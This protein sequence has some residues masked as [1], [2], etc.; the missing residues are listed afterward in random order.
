MSRQE[1]VFALLDSLH[2]DYSV[3]NHPAVF[4]IAEIDKLN[5]S[6]NG[7]VCKNL[8]LRD[9]KGARHFLVVM[10]KDKSANLKM[11]QEQ[12][13]CTRLSFA[14]TERLSKYLQLNK[15]E[16]SPFGI[17]NDN[18]R[19]VEV[20]LDNDLVGQDRLGFHPNDNTATVWISFDDI[21]G[22]IE[23]HGNALHFV[24]I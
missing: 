6:L 1:R 10:C 9:S 23:Q 4:T 14:S 5:L 16:V 21:K 13:H 7:H 19:S 15:G 8:F 12:L 17:I 2:I 18:S 3:M 24:S 11:I 22:V 20:V